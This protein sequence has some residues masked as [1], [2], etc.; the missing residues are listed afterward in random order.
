MGPGPGA[1]A[2][3]ASR[4]PPADGGAPG[5]CD[6]FLDFTPAINNGGTFTR[7]NALTSF[8][9]S[10]FFGLQGT[11][12]GGGDIQEYRGSFVTTTNAGGTFEATHA[13]AVLNGVLYAGRG[14]TVGDGQ[15]FYFRKDRTV[16]QSLTFQAGS[17]TGNLWF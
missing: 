7:V 13:F 5:I 11:A 17:S 12:A 8:D 4:A 15:V 9:G 14:P 3:D 1:G 6:N 16:S 10:L 2:G